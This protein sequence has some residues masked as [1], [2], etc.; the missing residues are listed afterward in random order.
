[1]I[2]N[3]LILLVSFCNLFSHYCNAQKTL[4]TDVLVIGGGTGGTAAGIQSARSGAK[5]I[6]VESGPW[7]GGMISAAGVSAI[8]GNHRLPS[9]LWAEFRSR[10]YQVYG[11][12]KAVETGWVSNTLF[13][14]HVADSIF[15]SMASKE[16]LLNVLFHYS[17]QSVQLSGRKISSIGF[18]NVKT[19]ESLKIQARI[20]IDATEL[21]DVMKA[22]GVPYDLGMEA[23]SLTGESVG[24]EQSNDFVQD[25]TYVATLKD[26]GAGSDHTIE[27]PAMYDPAEFDGACT[28]YYNDKSRKAPSVNARK[29]LEYGKLPKN[30]YMINWPIYGNDT[31]LNIVEMNEEQRRVELEKAKQTTL[32]FVYFIQHQLGFKNLGLAD[33]EFPTT[34]RLALMPYHREGRRVKG[35][36]RLTMRNIAEPFTFGDPLYRTGISVGDYPIDH[37]HKKNPLAPQHLEFYAIPSFNVPLGTL[38]PQNFDNLIIAEKGISVSNV[39]NGTTRL[40]P[41]VLLTGQAAGMLAALSSLKGILPHKVPV[42]SVQQNLLKA[43]AYIMPYIDVTP[44]NP[45]FEAVQKIGATGILKG[46]GVPNNWANQT[47][48]YPD[49]LVKSSDVVAALNDF[50][51]GSYKTTTIFLSVEEAIQLAAQLNNGWIKKSTGK[52]LSDPAR[53]AESK[54]SGWGL[55]DFSLSRNITRLELAVLLQQTADPFSMK[56]IDHR[57]YHKTR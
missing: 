13:E 2:R 38:I 21:G 12:S 4:V 57:G 24:V 20:F 47:W 43:K 40:Q 7:L 3:F 1:M 17:F 41:C 49:S 6:L 14:P 54:W 37:H 36:V 8:D 52:E 34:D 42:R 11:G 29:M 30:K 19:G 9:G 46:T 33:D 55:K 28:D 25:L 35:L 22:A 18:R 45:H 16:S 50:K 32:R 31:Y 56:A 5:T 26:Y 15:K 23:G 27:K 44:E 39:V 10:L 48:F 51:K 53:V